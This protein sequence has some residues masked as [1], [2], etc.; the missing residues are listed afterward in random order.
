MTST[1]QLN[2]DTTPPAITWGAVVDAVGSEEMTVYYTVNE[3]GVTSAELRMIDGR[4]VGMTVL[5]D[6]LTVV[7]PDDALE[8]NATVRVVL[9]DSAGN[10]ATSDLPVH[11]VGLTGPPSPAPYAPPPG[12]P[13]PPER[14][15][16]IV[17]GFERTRGRLGSAYGQ[18]T[19]GRRLVIGRLSSEHIPPAPSLRFRFSSLSMSAT[20]T[21]RAEVSTR[22]MGKLSAAFSVHKR[23]EGPGTE[24]DLI[25]LD[26]L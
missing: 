17:T 5:S 9:R 4:N 20:H 23:P 16:H 8:Q 18:T 12:L 26:L 24:D 2:L 22:S 21:V 6:R 7:I 13:S 19:V 1:F 10:T 15:R 14:T 11:V 25:L 3:P